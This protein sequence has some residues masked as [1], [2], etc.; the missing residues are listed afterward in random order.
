MYRS[1][2]CLAICLLLAGQGCDRHGEIKLG[3]TGQLT[4]VSSDLGVQGRN[5]AQLAVERVNAAGGVAGRRLKLLAEDD[6]YTPQDAQAADRA[7]L[8]AGVVA[9]VG[10][11]TSGQSMAALAQAAAAR[12]PLVSPTTATPELTGIKDNFFRVIPD[13]S[14]W[15]YALAD[16][17]ARNLKLDRVCVVGD[18]DNA[19][20]TRSFDNAFMERFRALGGEVAGAWEF[21]SRSGPD[22]AAQLAAVLATGARAVVLS[23]SARDVAAFA[24]ARALAG[25]GLTI[26][27]PAWPSTREILLAGGSSVEGVLFATSHAEDN[28]SPEFQRF[29]ARY[30]ERFGW[31]PNFAAAFA[32]DAVLL[33]AAALEK[34]GGSRQGLE[35]ALADTGELH[36]ALGPFRLDAFGDV[37]R[38][39]F[40]ITIREGRF[41]SVAGGGG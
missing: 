16:H 22:W 23:A 12:V 28:P 6:G 4:G 18:A 30:E 20:Y 27:C 41:R 37:E 1:I 5:G 40:I 32:H 11:M 39:T 9:L 36:G 24:Q 21:S 8:E 3:F 15:A 7:L 10:H 33:L 35:T 14:R 25:A 29:R 31:P 17:A 19:S 26:L 13:S 38:A 34:T 2:L